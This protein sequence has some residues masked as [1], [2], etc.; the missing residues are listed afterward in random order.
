[1]GNSGAVVIIRVDIEVPPGEGS[2]RISPL[3]KGFSFP[4]RYAKVTAS[5][6][7]ATL[8]SLIE[9]CGAVVVAAGKAVSKTFPPVEGA[10]VCAGDGACA[11][12]VLNTRR[13]VRM[14]V[15]MKRPKFSIMPQL[16]MP[17]KDKDRRNET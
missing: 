9:V 2:F 1:M 13:A 12:P 10:G 11:Q 3:G 14:P 8:S 4:F 17:L 6:T 16:L 7:R 5:C 15:V